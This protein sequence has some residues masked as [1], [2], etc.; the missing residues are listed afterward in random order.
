VIGLVSLLLLLKF[1]GLYRGI[2]FAPKVFVLGV[3][4]VDLLQLLK[5]E[6]AVRPLM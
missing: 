1:A 2:P 5:Q 3:V 6:T 4:F